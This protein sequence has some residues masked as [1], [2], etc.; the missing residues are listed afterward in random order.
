M[1]WLGVLLITGVL[2]SA[3]VLTPWRVSYLTEATGRAT[4]DE[5]AQRLGPPNLIHSLDSGQVVWLYKYP[6]AAGGDS[7]CSQYILTFDAQRI[8]KNWVRQNC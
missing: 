8:L 1:K 3:C 2:V 5:V 6:G 7:Y 4:Q